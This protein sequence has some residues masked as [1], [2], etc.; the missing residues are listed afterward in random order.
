MGIVTV[1]SASARM[2]LVVIGP[3]QSEARSVLFDAVWL[4]L[5]ADSW[6]ANS[7]NTAVPLAVCSTNW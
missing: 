7:S 4:F 3:V 5:D 2:G 1:V 6:R